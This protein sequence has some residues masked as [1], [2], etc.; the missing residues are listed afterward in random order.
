MFAVILLSL[1][2]SSP[3]SPQ[4]TCP[5]IDTRIVHQNVK[6][7][8]KNADRYV[9]N[10]HL[11]GLLNYWKAQCKS[12]RN[13]ASRAVVKDLVSL[14]DRSASRLAAAQ[15]LSDVGFNLRHASS[16]I[17]RALNE[18]LSYDA[19]ISERSGPYFFLRT[20]DVTTTTDALKCVLHKARSG[21]WDATLCSDIET[22]TNSETP[23]SE[24]QG[25]SPAAPREAANSGDTTT[26]SGDTIPN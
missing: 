7:V 23:C 2:F 5:P 25:P 14:L 15:M 18:E 11:A 4:S 19:S 26:N 1:H 16:A 6:G 22:V 8:I 17:E 20:G 21:E 13:D 9:S 12:S 24:W 3:S 10:R